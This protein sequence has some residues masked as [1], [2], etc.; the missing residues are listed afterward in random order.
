M[1]TR[2]PIRPARRLAERPRGAAAA[3]VAMLLALSLASAQTT[4]ETLGLNGP[5]AAMEEYREY[6][7]TTERQLFQTWVFDAAGVAVERVFFQYNFMDGSLRARQVTGY[8]AGRPL[9]TV[10]YDADDQPIGQTVFRY[11]GEGRRIE[12]VTV[13][14]EGVETRRVVVEHDAAGRVVR[15][16]QYRDGALDRS[17][18]ADYD[19]GGERLE[20][21]RFDAEGRMVRIAR[22]GVPGREYAYVEYDE[23]GEVVATGSVVESEFGTVLIEVLAPGGSVDESYAWTYDERGRVLERRSIYDEGQREELLSYAYDDDDRGNWVRQVT[24]EDD[25]FGPEPSEIR[26]RVI[27]YR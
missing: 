21:R 15:W 18:E 1:L 24:T 14:A 6:P 11:D 16:T 10:T 9:A 17:W 27:R 23:V 8:D 7:G 3:T 19:A 12:E 20:E 25:G 26:D 2:P 5:V 22:Y 13:D 4:T